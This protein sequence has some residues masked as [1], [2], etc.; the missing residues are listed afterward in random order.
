MRRTGG[1]VRGGVG[2]GGYPTTTAVPL[3]Q[4]IGIA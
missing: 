1:A 2:N 4:T 3:A